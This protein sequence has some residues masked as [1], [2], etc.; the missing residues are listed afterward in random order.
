[1]KTVMKFYKPYIFAVL[2]IIGV[3]FGQAMCE[4]ALP[5]YMSK[6]INKGIVMQDLETIKSVGLIMIVVAF[7][8]MVFSISGSFIASRVAAKSAR[9]IR[10]ALF[11]RVMEFS[12]AEMN[13]FS[14]ASLIT[15]ST[16]DVQSVQMTTVM[17][18]RMAIFSPIMGVGALINAVN[19]K[20]S[21]TWIIGVTLAGIIVLMLAIFFMVMPKFRVLQLKLDKLNLLIKE[22]LSGLLVVRAFNTEGLEE[23]RFDLAN[24]DLTKINIFINRVMSFMFPALMVIMNICSIM[25]VWFGSK[26]ADHGNLMIGDM[27]ALLQYAMHIILSFLFIAAMFIMIPRAAVS[28]R[29]I[30]AV[31]DV[32]PGIR[33]PEEPVS[34]EEHRG[35]IEFRDVSFAFPDAARN[36]IDHVSFKAEPGH[37]TAI[38]GGT[39]SGKSTLLNLILRFYDVTEGQILMDGVDIRKLELKELRDMIGYVPQKGLLFSGTIGSNIKTGNEE[40]SGEEVMEA[41]RVAQADGFI[42]EK[43]EGLDQAVAQGGT[44][45]SG[46]QKQR[47]SI[48]RAL[49]KKAPVYLFDDS[50]SALDFRTDRELRKALRESTADSTFIIVAQRINTIMDADQI[51]TMDRGRIAGIGTHRE[52]LQN[53]DVYREIAASQLSEEELRKEGI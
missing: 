40:A 33:D 51:I 12:P 15:R 2:L 19:T 41:A 25:I 32:E 53:C 27:L 26:M 39:G 46:G 21:L 16:N 3:L 24:L 45:V 28:M 43:P 4:L 36:S 11:H 18:L 17:M 5:G 35:T 42:M 47:L 23:K 48:A 7:A 13:Q 1:M 30:G 52:L 14:T 10:A 50:F 31:L 49:M 44:N 6:I 22:R 29:R 34:I 9:D 37:T 20:A 8:S 38:V